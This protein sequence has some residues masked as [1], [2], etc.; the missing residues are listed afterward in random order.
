[1]PSIHMQVELVTYKWPEWLRA[2]TEKQRIIWA[3]KVLFLDVLFPLNVTRVI[4]C[5]SDQI[6]RHD[7]VRTCTSG[8]QA[9]TLPAV[10]LP[11]CVA[12]MLCA[13][14][15]LACVDNSIADA[16]D[17]TRPRACSTFLR[18]A[19]LRVLHTG[20]LVPACPCSC[21]AST[22][23]ACPG[24]SAQ[25]LSSSPLPLSCLLLNHLF[26]TCP[27]PTCVAHPGA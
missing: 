11:R 7:M 18:H 27:I 1:M 4:F 23:H 12:S 10:Q 2:Q 14:I 9:G 15:S 25:V 17:T 3:Y 22:P 8:M 26:L 24:S 6:I 19:L 20:P 13:G 16:H 5:D 21:P